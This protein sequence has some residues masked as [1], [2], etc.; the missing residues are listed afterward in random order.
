M[1]RVELVAATVAAVMGVALAGCSAM[2]DWMTP[3]FMSSSS[4]PAMQPLRF[5]SDPPGADVRT[6]QGQTCQ[7]P[8][9]LGVPSQNQAV[10][11]TK[12]GYVAQT[13]QVTTAAPPEHSFW[14]SPP[15]SLT[16]NPVQVV[17]QQIPPPPPHHKREITHRPRTTSSAVP[18]TRT[19]AKNTPPRRGQANPFPDPQP[20]QQ[21]EAAP[22]PF[23]PPPPIAPQQQ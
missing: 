10:T 6:A 9:A 13:V 16:P 12:V 19:A 17:L 23:P 4:E 1:S 18:R 20:V 7:T 11:F 22:S 15:P 14:E 2:P 3:S 8:C 21:Q 5:E